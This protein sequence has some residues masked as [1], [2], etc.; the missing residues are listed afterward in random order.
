MT[1][2]N[3]HVEQVQTRRDV[4]DFIRFPFTLYRGDP[5]WA[6]PLL[7][8]RRQFLDPKHN[9]FFDHA[10]VAL[11]LARRNGQVVGTISSHVDHLHNKIHEEK[12]G[13]L[14]FF[15][16][17]DD[18][19]VAEALFSTARDWVRAQGMV[20]LRGPLSF[21]QNDECG[22]LIDGFDG[23]PMVMMP[24]NPRYYIEFY[25][26]FG[27]A[28]AMDLYAYV[29]DLTQFGGGPNKLPAKLVRVTEK[30]QKRAG[31]TMRAV[32][33]KAYDEE[34][35]R[36]K[37]VYNRAWEKNWGFVPMTDAEFDRLAADLK[38][39]LDPHLAIVA[40][41]EGEPVGV[42]VAVPDVN[43]VLKH[44]NGRLFPIGWIKALWYAR[45]VNQARLMIMGVVENY[46]GR[47][48]ESLLMFES[49]KAAIENGYQAIEM[50]WILEN[51]DMMNR[52][53]LNLG[54]AYGAYVYRTYRIY[55]MPV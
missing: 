6:P 19:A 15:E 3:V 48:I 54:E 31:I 40:E 35:Q 13:M 1:D 47:G 38:Q 44:L 49:L 45:K 23:P 34:I 53:V 22:L 39:A 2:K 25:E 8:Q 20:A 10:D 26:R 18:Y 55:Q 9:P 36:T 24:Y 46:R 16:T 50:S 21:S 33:M 12:I 11:W 5:N 28:K 42:S 7:S 30:V 51:N 32:D 14:G 52:I 27:L 41:V 17:I 29:A 37:A 43:Q 4:E